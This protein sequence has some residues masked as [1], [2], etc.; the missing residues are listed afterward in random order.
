MGRPPIA[1][2][3]S[4]PMSFR[5]PIEVKAAA[6]KAAAADSRSVASLV[7]KVLTDFL[8]KNGYLPK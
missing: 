8:R 7:E 5:L 6:E 3:K 4:L 2:P 1:N